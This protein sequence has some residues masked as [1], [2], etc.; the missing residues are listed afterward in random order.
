[1]RS[2]V[3]THE[4]PQL[5]RWQLL[6]HFAGS[7]GLEVEWSSKYIFSDIEVVSRFV[8]N[9]FFLQQSTLGLAQ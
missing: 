8:K 4:T 9:Y 7:Y 1:M 5:D 2:K 3:C 6:R